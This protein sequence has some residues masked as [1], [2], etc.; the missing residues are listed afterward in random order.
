MRVRAAIFDLYETLITEFSDGKRIFRRQ[1]DDPD[2][3]GLSQDEFKR[4][5][6]ARQERRM[7]GSFP[8][9]HAVIRDILE[10]R[11]LSYPHEHVEQ[12]YR[13][14]VEEK[15]LPFQS[16]R[17]D[18]LEMLDLLKKRGIKLGL[19]SNCTEE[20]VIHFGRSPLASCFD[21]VIF[22]YEVGMAKPQKEIYLMACERLGVTP[23]ES[24]FVGDGGSD[25]LRGARD[26][27]LQPYHAYWFNTYIE[28]GFRKLHAPLEVQNILDHH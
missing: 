4:E 7:N 5:W 14:R 20:E 12:L 26:A 9:F 28:S 24:I 13:A 8:T 17:S 22:S 23:E 10:Q 3:L 21:E 6:R 18:I 1:Q 15:G 11:S 27:G 2:R 16:I 25:E 19:I